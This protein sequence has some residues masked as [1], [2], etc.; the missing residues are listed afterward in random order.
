[1]FKPEPMAKITLT[2]LRARLPQLSQTLA[3][4]HL[5]HL[6]DYQGDDEGFVT[7]APLAYGAEV[8]ERLVRVRSLFK[9]FDVSAAPPEEPYSGADI[10][11]K[12]ETELDD[13]EARTLG[14]RDRLRTARRDREEIRNRLAL[15]QKFA[16]LELTLAALHGYRSLVVFTGTLPHKA[17]V[18]LPAGELVRGDGIVAAFVPVAQEAEAKQALTVAGFKAVEPPTGDDLPQREAELTEREL[19]RLE[20]GIAECKAERE[21]LADHHGRWLV[22]AEEHLMAKAAKSELPLKLALSD[23]AFVLEG[24]LPCDRLAELE[25]ALAGSG[26]HL[27][28]EQTDDDPPLALHNPRAV[29][30]FEILTKMY[31]I[32]RWGEIDPT[33]FMF[34]TYPLFFGLMVGDAGYGLVYLLLGHLLVTRFVHDETIAALGHILRTAGIWTIFFGLF[35]FAE[36]FGLEI[37]A[38]GSQLPFLLHKS[39]PADVSFLLKA[40][41]GLG[42]VFLTVGLTIGF[43]NELKLHGLKHA[44]MTKGSWLMILWGGMIFLPVWLL[45]NALIGSGAPLEFNL[46]VIVFLAGITLATWGEGIVAIVEVPAIFIN[47]IS[48][49]RIAALGVADY[50]LATALN[51]IAWDLG[52]HGYH[53]IFTIV[54]LVLGHALIITLAL[55][56]S[57]INSLRLHY[58]E[59]FP[60]FFMGGGVDYVPFGYTRK[61]TQEMEITT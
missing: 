16:S 48:Y 3:R 47:V 56:G 53:A 45:D 34:I 37:H 22:A 26:F 57:G 15:L 2:G 14:L 55:I 4:L 18:D 43:L 51:G 46:A 30:P 9:L 59:C 5:V 38:L 35:L 6:V 13:V 36:A 8:S 20:A 39:N 27:T 29:R 32:P 23:N 44:V 54:I 11:H 61:Y 52:F 41:G 17:T 49:V 21:A 25:Q 1:M 60:K 50:E 10:D 58:V 12:L 19:T 28:K 31:D 7:G 33:A 24:W 40:T 42:L